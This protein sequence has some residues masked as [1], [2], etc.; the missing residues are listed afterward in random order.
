[1]NEKSN[2]SA[3]P[4]ASP[5]PI[6]PVSALNAED[7]NAFTTVPGGHSTIMVD[8]VNQQ[9][10][11]F[12]ELSENVDF[13]E[14][15]IPEN[16]LPD[17]VKDAKLVLEFIISDPPAPL[18]AI[19]NE[20]VGMFRSSVTSE[21]P[22]ALAKAIERA[23]EVHVAN[24][25]RLTALRGKRVSINL[26]LQNIPRIY[27]RLTAVTERLLALKEADALHAPPFREAIKALS[28]KIKQQ[29]Q[30]LTGALFNLDRMIR[31]Y[32]RLILI[33]NYT[34][35]FLRESST[36]E[37]VNQGRKP[38]M[39]GLSTTAFPL[40]EEEWSLATA[41]S[42]ARARSEGNARTR[43][44]EPFA[45]I[46]MPQRAFPLH[47][48]SLRVAL[49]GV[50]R[51][52]PLQA[53]SIY[54]DHPVRITLYGWSH[55]HQ[56]D[57]VLDGIQ[58]LR[59]MGF[60]L[61]D[62]SPFRTQK[63]TNIRSIRLTSGAMHD[64]LW[65]CLLCRLIELP[66]GVPVAI[67]AVV[68]D[69]VPN[70]PP[71]FHTWGVLN[72]AYPA[73]EPHQFPLELEARF[74][75]RN[76]HLLFNPQRLRPEWLDTISVSGVCDIVFRSTIDLLRYQ[77]LQPSAKPFLLSKISG[78]RANVAGQS[79]TIQKALGPFR[80]QLYNVL[81]TP[82]TVVQ[83]ILSQH[84]IVWDG[85]DTAGQGA[86]Q[87]HHI[88]F[89]A[90]DQ[91]F[92]ASRLLARQT[93]PGVNRGS[94]IQLSLD[95]GCPPRNC[96][97]CYHP[98]KPSRSTGHT[99]SEC[100]HKDSMCTICHQEDHLTSACAWQN[101]TTFKAPA[102]SSYIPVNDRISARHHPGRER[103]RPPKR[104]RRGTSGSSRG[105]QGAPAAA[106]PRSA[107]PRPAAAVAADV[108]SALTPPRATAVNRTV[109]A[110]G[111]I[112]FQLRK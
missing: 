109:Q 23:E 89:Q 72:Q 107:M 68:P 85:Y 100:P 73:F 15:L 27:V 93:F 25:T 50:S 19:Q 111:S 39:V 16:T 51:Y 8:A 84:N 104:G 57:A 102:P 78:Q 43:R 20:L 18:P 97:H 41:A 95:L 9:P 62:L 17:V 61:T 83:A 63:S 13:L 38:P 54:D 11:E 32:G 98:D 75:E 40:A 69:P 71:M 28:A 52:M 82:P 99:A 37:R 112:T 3:T 26:H 76:I 7:T 46:P 67:K 64:Q 30:A 106:A 22:G 58:K 49:D 2:P 21:L 105:D 24:L 80:L 44:Q 96:L 66:S 59:N 90:D 94:P 1:M 74:A 48:Q 42:I 12:L 88:G 86:R 14:I 53:H 34:N 56:D 10:E 47:C 45:L 77:E 101:Q 35:H 110:D 87:T 31:H 5:V 36:E 55:S 79:I 60:V 81:F 6:Q 108:A 29:Q 70:D 33:Q 103:Q 92:E 91:R 4:A 65:Q